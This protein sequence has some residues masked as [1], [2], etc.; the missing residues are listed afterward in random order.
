[1]KNTCMD[2]SGYLEVIAHAM[3]LDGVVFFACRDSSGMEYVRSYIDGEI[4][5]TYKHGSA[6]RFVMSL[7]NSADDMAGYC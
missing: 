3:P 6:Y 1:M 5:G 4:S 2:H 7:E